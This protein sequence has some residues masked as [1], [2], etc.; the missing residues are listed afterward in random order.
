MAKATLLILSPPTETARLVQTLF[1][2]AARKFGLPWVAV[3]RAPDEATAEER[4]AAKRVVALVPVEGAEVWD[5]PPSADA[6]SVEPRVNQLLARLLG[7][8]GEPPPEPTPSPTEKPT[9]SQRPVVKVGRETKGRKGKGVTTVS[10]VPLDDAGLKE[11]AATLKQRC[12]S[13]GGVEDGRIVLQGDLR[14]RVA[15]ELEKLGYR[16]KRVGG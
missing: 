9:P 10:E 16:V 6:A 12:G 2:S 7:G 14:D 15:A 8:G 11:L 1:E 13:G 5:L 3:V 4:Q